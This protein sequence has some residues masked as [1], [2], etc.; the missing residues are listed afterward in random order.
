MR[1]L[2]K[3][4]KPRKK[5]V[6]RESSREF[7]GFSLLE[8]MLLN[9][10]SQKNLDELKR[11]YTD[12]LE[13]ASRMQT[14]RDQAFKVV[15]LVFG[16][17]LINYSVTPSMVIEKSYNF[18]S[19]LRLPSER[20]ASF[21]DFIEYKSTN[22]F[23]F[24]IFIIDLAKFFNYHDFSIF[25]TPRGLV[26]QIGDT[27]LAVS[28]GLMTYNQDEVEINL[29]IHLDED[30]FWIPSSLVRPWSLLYLAEKCIKKEDRFI[31][32]RKA[33]A[34]LLTQ[35]EELNTGGSIDDRLNR[36]LSGLY[37][38]VG[39]GLFECGELN[40]ASEAIRKA[41]E[42]NPTDAELLVILACIYITQN[43]FEETHT[44]LK[45]AYDRNVKNQNLCFLLGVLEGTLNKD[46]KK[47][48]NYF[49]E[50][51]SLMANPME[52]LDEDL[53]F[54]A[55]RVLRE[56][57]NSAKVVNQMRKIFADSPVSLL[58][59]AHLFGGLGKYE[60]ALACCEQCLQGSYVDSEVYEIMAAALSRLGRV[61]AAR[62]SLFLA[63][64]LK[65][66]KKP[67]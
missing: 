17:D 51:R 1:E 64:E 52:A 9:N 12:M 48:N 16:P 29:K 32:Y 14:S 53:I 65:Q 47:A 36:S 3:D 20:D 10:R 42:L 13:R 40:L 18:L 31:Y 57:D 60:E 19:E 7:I 54:I 58:Q 67:A 24:A 5:E 22:L 6:V 21:L 30:A 33:L 61:E 62:E 66:R 35:E 34:L 28:T 44:L 8:T 2:V 39:F 25:S 46:L 56:F 11:A 63:R 50:A 37:A 4:L 45:Q 59:L 23:I 43:L 38:E 55:L 49:S 26:L 41:Y 27:F 15:K